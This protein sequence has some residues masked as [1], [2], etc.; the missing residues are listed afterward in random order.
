MYEPDPEQTDNRPRPEDGAQD[1]PTSDP[2]AVVVGAADAAYDPDVDG[3]EDSDDM[4]DAV[5]DGDADEID[6]GV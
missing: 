1:V 5:L 3:I 4:V 6:G 2:T